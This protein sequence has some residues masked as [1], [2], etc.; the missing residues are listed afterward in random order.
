MFILIFSFSHCCNFSTQLKFFF[1]KITLSK[2]PNLSIHNVSFSNAISFT[3]RIVKIEKVTNV[4]ICFVK[5]DERI[6]SWWDWW[7]LHNFPYC[8]NINFSS[9]PTNATIH[10]I[11]IYLYRYMSDILGQNIIEN[12]H[13]INLQWFYPSFW[14]R[15]CTV[16]HITRNFRFFSSIKLVL[17][18]TSNFPALH[19]WKNKQIVF[20]L[21]Y[22]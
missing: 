21:S 9:R 2:L 22:L 16:T 3:L 20:F 14:T 17:F 15:G 12:I 10:N 8:R 11:Y 18:S 19:R 6:F 5:N 7:N 13:Y 1:T 4:C